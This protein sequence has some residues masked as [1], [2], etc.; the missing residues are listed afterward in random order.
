MI[1]YV[2]TAYRWGLRDAHSYVV[3]VRSTPA[4]ARVVARQ[5]VSYRGGAYGCEVT[6]H[7]LTAG[8]CDFKTVAYF[9][10]PYFGAAGRR[11]PAVDPVDP[12]KML[13]PSEIAGENRS[14]AASR[15]EAAKRRKRGKA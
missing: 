10:S 11:Y 3:G 4:K 1:A 8:R 2:I 5:E 12:A 7:K 15:R 14:A 13:L 9:E 6:R